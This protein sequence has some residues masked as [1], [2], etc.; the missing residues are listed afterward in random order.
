MA[1]DTMP[2]GLIGK[3]RDDAI[4]ILVDN[5]VEYQVLYR[6]TCNHHM[7]VIETD[8]KEG[9]TFA[10]GFRFATITVTTGS[11][12]TVPNIVGLDPGAAQRTLNNKNLKFKL[13]NRIPDGHWCSIWQHDG[14]YTDI[15]LQSPPAGRVVCPESVV[16]ATRDERGR[17]ISQMTPRGCL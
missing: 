7:T 2:T 3:N 6:N 5:S 14:S 16:T 1:Q 15:Y 17:R 12:E 13:E 10:G 4:Q 11:A 9:A 8:P